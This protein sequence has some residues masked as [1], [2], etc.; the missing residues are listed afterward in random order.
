MFLNSSQ[1]FIEFAPFGMRTFLLPVWTWNSFQ[2]CLVL[3]LC[4]SFADWRTCLASTLKICLKIKFLLEYLRS[5][6][7]FH[8]RLRLNCFLCPFVTMHSFLEPWF[9]TLQLS[10]WSQ[11]F[12]ARFHFWPPHWIFLSLEYWRSEPHFFLHWFWESFEPILHF[13]DLLDQHYL[14]RNI[15]SDSFY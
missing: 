2:T 5:I 14:A 7:I 10:V 12:V 9:S 6:L 11:S 15:C 3:F 1:C 13:L 8:L 4:F